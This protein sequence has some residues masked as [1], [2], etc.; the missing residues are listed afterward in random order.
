MI[1]VSSVIFHIFIHL[2][3]FRHSVFS[4]LFA[5]KTVLVMFVFRT[6]D[7]APLF[8]IFDIFLSAGVSGRIRTFDLRIMSGVFY[9]CATRGMYHKTYYGRN[10][11][12]P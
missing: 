1:S 6:F 8:Q 2:E 9:P 4:L 7:K 12:F 11:Q 5:P 3:L 10:F